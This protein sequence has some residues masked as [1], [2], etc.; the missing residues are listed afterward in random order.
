MTDISHHNNSK[1]LMIKTITVIFTEITD[2]DTCSALINQSNII[3]LPIQIRSNWNFDILTG[4][5]TDLKT[6]T[7]TAYLYRS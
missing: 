6:H 3:L 5:Y 2:A 1:I 4:T 7:N